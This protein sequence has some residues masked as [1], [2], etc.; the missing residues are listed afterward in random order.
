MINIT[1]VGSDGQEYPV[2]AA[3]G[4][5]LMRAALD[6]GVPGI[7]GDCGGQGTCA[8]C[9]GYIDNSFLSRLPEKSPDEV[10]MLECAIDPEANSRLTCQI[11][12]TPDL[13]GLRVAIPASQI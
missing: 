13:D 9:H 2:T 5:S 10:D 7:I 1:F 4:T 12:V 11:T 6:H 3:P 8:T